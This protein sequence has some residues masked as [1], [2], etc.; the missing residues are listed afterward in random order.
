MP[1]RLHL[2]PTPPLALHQRELDRV[3]AT[4]LRHDS[5]RGAATHH[6]HRPPDADG[7][8]G[9]AADRASGYDPAVQQQPNPTAASTPPPRV[10]IADDAPA[11]RAALRGLLEDHG[12]PVIGEAADGLQ[13][14][15]MATQLQPDVVV[16]DV[17]TSGLDGLQATKRN[18]GAHPNIRVVVYSVYD[19]D[20][21]RHAAHQAGAAPSSLNTPRP[22]TS[23]PP[24]SPPGGRPP[25]RQ[26]RHRA[27]IRSNAAGFGTT[28]HR[29]VGRGRLVVTT[30]LL[31]VP[32]DRPGGA[33]M[34]AAIPHGRDPRRRD[35]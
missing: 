34:V 23:P 5:I 4:L 15:T 27:T 30:E 14:I 10:L 12:L 2:Q 20:Q 1:P 9:P 13:A 22:T 31:Q 21:T 6:Q 17:R 35:P 29:P 19:S 3:I 28:H 8:L 11:M 7:S 24:C 18:T 32:G 26:P 16:M 33:S 25:P